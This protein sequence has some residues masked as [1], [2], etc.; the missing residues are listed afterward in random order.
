MGAS[1]IKVSFGKQPVRRLLGEEASGASRGGDRESYIVECV[2]LQ[3]T[4]VDSVLR[5][6]LN[7]HTERER[8]NCVVNSVHYYTK[9][10]KFSI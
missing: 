8:E 9:L 5:I 1:F 6:Q 4:V 10:N 2:L 7:T 3:L